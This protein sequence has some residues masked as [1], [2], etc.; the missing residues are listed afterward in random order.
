MAPVELVPSG[1]RWN[2]WKDESAKEFL[3]ATS[4]C[5]L[6]TSCF[7]C[8]ANALLL[9]LFCQFTSI[10]QTCKF[11]VKALADMELVA[12]GKVCF[13]SFTT[14]VSEESLCMLF[15]IQTSMNEHYKAGQLQYLERAELLCKVP[16]Q[17]KGRP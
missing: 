6:K 10:Y 1:M 5:K 13:N 2:V 16:G 12:E 14:V 9:C 7:I 17:R 11:R 8:F 15:H 4:S 3:E